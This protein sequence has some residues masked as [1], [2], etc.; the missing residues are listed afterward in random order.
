MKQTFTFFSVFFLSFSMYAQVEPVDTD[1]D[2]FRN[3]TTLDNLKWITE[4]SSSWGDKFKLDN[5]IDASSTSTWTEYT[6]VIGFQPIATGYF[7]KFTGMIDGNGHKISGLYIHSDQNGADAAF[8][9]KATD[10]T[11]ENLTLENCDILSSDGGA[12][13]L[14]GSCKST[15][16]TNCKSSGVVDGDGEVGGLIGVASEAT[17]STCTS[18]VNIPCE[19][20]TVGGLIASISKSTVVTD[21]YATGDVQGNNNV[22]GCIGFSNASTTTNCYSTGPVSGNSRPTGG[23]IGGTMSATIT[24][25]YSSSSV[26]LT[27]GSGE[28]SGGF[29]GE[30]GSGS[31]ITLCYATGAVTSEDTEVGGFVGQNNGS[32]EKCYATGNVI[33]HAVAGGFVGLNEMSTA[34]IKNCYSTGNVFVDVEGHQDAGGFA[35][36]NSAKAQLVNDYS[37]GKVEAPNSTFTDLGGFL[38]TNRA[39]A[40]EDYRGIVTNSYWNTSTSGLTTSLGG[41]GK[42]ASEMKQAAMFS[43]WDFTSTWSIVPETNNG[44]PHLANYV[45]A[46]REVSATVA[47]SVYPN[48][49]SQHITIV[50]DCHISSIQIYSIEGK[51]VKQVFNYNHGSVDIS[52]LKFGVY[53]V[54][55]T[56]DKGNGFTRFL[57]N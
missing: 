40:P 8:I 43:G 20:N 55:I 19:H 16:V 7:D 44:Y 42:S 51:L 9:A 31:S 32:I 18:S 26:T 53:L 56:T 24:N 41:E 11:I 46:L 28:K 17:I 6:D 50:S 12:A 25:C 36:E 39:S 57:K 47:L 13:A 48:P 30:N 23:F 52:D 54:D 15:V 45:S 21:S 34:I 33:A 37:T 14:I 38:G 3:V 27:G 2:G 4:N 10:A 29:V 22:G 49:S 35:G 5:D 1:A